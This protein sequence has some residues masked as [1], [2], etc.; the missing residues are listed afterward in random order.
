MRDYVLGGR[1]SH[2]A[3]AISELEHQLK[4]IDSALSTLRALG[5][6]GR[7]AAATN[8]GLGR[9]KRHLSAQGRAKI[10]AAVKKRWAAQRAAQNGGAAKESAV[11][12]K[13]AP[14]KKARK[15]VL[16]A[17]ARKKMALA[18]KKRWAAQKKKAT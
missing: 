12:K 3:S 14:A 15:R 7:A 13:V 8:S 2:I 16:S 5:V 4:T 1:V 11:P 6:S 18:A 10:V 17:E 9:K